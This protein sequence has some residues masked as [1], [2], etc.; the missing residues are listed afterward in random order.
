MVGNVLWVGILNV[1]RFRGKGIRLMGGFGVFGRMMLKCKIFRIECFVFPFPGLGDF[2]EG[3]GH[4]WMR[5]REVSRV[6]FVSE[7]SKH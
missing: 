4:M 6:G 1:M 5:V 2:P 7:I 3:F